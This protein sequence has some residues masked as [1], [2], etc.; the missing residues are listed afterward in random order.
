MFRP[1]IATKFAP[2]SFPFIHSPTA[3]RQPIM[4]TRKAL[5]LATRAILAATCV[6]LAGVP[7]PARAAVSFLGVA[8]GDATTTGATA[9]TRALDD[10]STA[11]VPLTLQVSADPQFLTFT[12]TAGATDPARDY[13]F[14]IDLTGLN[15]GTVYYYRFQ[16]A[17]GELSNTGR[18]KT[19]P[20]PTA[21]VPV[22]FAFSGDMDGLIRPYALASTIP[23]Q[24]FD[25][26][27]NDGDTI[28]ENA[29]KATGN[30]GATWLTSPSV[31]LS[32]TTPA[33]TAAG[34]TQAQLFADYSKKYRE[35]FLPVNTGGQN[36]LQPFYAAQGNYSLYDNHELGNRQY[37]NGG[38][39]AGGPVGDMPTGAGADARV[40][41]NDA[42]TSGGFINQ[43]T[44]FL[45]L[46]QVFLNYQPI[47]NRPLVN[48]P[49][50]PR[51]HG[52]KP[53]Y[54][55]QQW[56]KN[57][58]FINVDTRSYRDIRVK[59]GANA[60][61]T[62]A[63]ADN[64]ARTMLGATQLAWLEQTLLAAQNSGVTWKVIVVSDPIDQVGPIGGALQ[65][66][67]LPNF[68]PGSTY[69]PVSSDGG[70]SWQGGYRAERNALLKYIAD[71][72]I[73]NVVFLAT[74]DHQNRVNELTYSPTGQTGLQSSYVKV[75]YCFQI[76]AGPLGATGPDLITNHTFAMASQLSD[77]LFNAQVAANIEPFGLQ[78]YPGLHDVAREGDP[79]AGTSPRTVD[80]YSPDT[81][82][83]NVLDV[84]A[85]GKTLAVS[86]VGIFSTAQNSALEY[87]PAGN[88]AHQVFAFQVDAAGALI[89]RGGFSYNRR[90][91]SLLQTITVKNAGANPIL[92]PVYVALDSLSGN[93]ALTNKNGVTANA[94]PLGSPY[95]LASGG[96]LAGGASA[97]V[98]LQFANPA[99]G[100]VTYTAR[101]IVGVANP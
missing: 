2:A 12:P 75:P 66:S 98:T 78:G 8:A 87:D 6:A 48:A 52:T 4:K 51:S 50:D 95:I 20:L 43:T 16:A 26:F 65:L 33:P 55:S 90:T 37:I 39:P 67:N 63:R 68:G 22:H 45:T 34:A 85:D 28:Y 57:L 30:N 97:S 47:A 35:Q 32:G 56:G 53:L 76:V 21:A 3:G 10:L 71:N 72:Q 93:T 46:Q 13:T 79:N 15:P 80:F 54:F 7:G 25:F 91:A 23:A 64:P 14:K 17:T 27:V 24:N 99:S 100:A 94:A 19:A 89:S 42:N 82:N 74:D 31:T 86:S 40:S 81:F 73:P 96:D 60:D 1:L 41:A 59:T 36:C 5:S 11:A 9:W 44:G 38:A 62:G 58:V 61:D 92:G 101:A 88:P 84:G 69:T 70:K 49:A 18:F 29:S 83:Y 77:S